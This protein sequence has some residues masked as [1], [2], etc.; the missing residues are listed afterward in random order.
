MGDAEARVLG[1][2]ETIKVKVGDGEKEY[3]LSPVVSKHLCDLEREALKYYKRQHLSTFA[4]NVDLLEN[5][6][7]DVLVQQEMRTV[8]SWS[9][10]DLPQKDVFDTSQVPVTDKV[11]KWIEEKFETLPD[12]DDIA[13]AMLSTALDQG[14]VSP[15]EIKKLTG[16]GPMQGRVRYDQWWV[17]ACMEGMIS[18]IVSSLQLEYPSMTRKDVEKWSFSKV[19]EAARKVEQITTA[20]MGNT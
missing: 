18:F 10:H 2:G 1:A 6:Q 20:D 7:G 8:A 13:R 3:K 14:S 15:K 9:L 17:T 16:K 12:E 4:D 5:G 19:A 11:K